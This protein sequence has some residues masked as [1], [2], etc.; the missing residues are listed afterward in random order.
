MITAGCVVWGKITCRISSQTDEVIKDT[1]HWTHLK[2]RD[3]TG[4]D[5]IKFINQDLKDS[6]IEKDK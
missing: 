3:E 6:K 5:V 4:P 1:A 2:L